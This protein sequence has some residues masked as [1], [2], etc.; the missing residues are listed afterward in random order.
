MEIK[1]DVQPKS[2]NLGIILIDFVPYKEKEKMIDGMKRIYDA[3]H[4]D[5]SPYNFIDY[6]LVIHDF[7][8]KPLFSTD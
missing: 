2:K 7:R 1:K 8:T 5:F 6:N 4:S 3:A